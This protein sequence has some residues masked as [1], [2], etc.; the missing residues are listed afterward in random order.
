MFFKFYN[1]N[2]SSS[3]MS[4][5]YTHHQHNQCTR[6]DCNAS[7]H[8]AW[9]T[10]MPVLISAFLASKSD[11]DGMDVDGLDYHVFQ[12]DILGLR[13]NF[14]STFSHN[15]ITEYEYCKLIGQNTDE[16]ANVVLV[17]HGLLGASPTQP[18][19]AFTLEILKFYHQLHNCQ[20][21]LSIQAFIKVLCAI[22]NICYIL[23]SNTQAM[24]GLYTPPRIPC[25]VRGLSELSE[26]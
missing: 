9:T 20:R 1:T 10:Q 15:N 11:L 3:S 12:I 4:S 24:G 5:G 18:A 23:N 2:R 16:E 17:C 6:Q 21:S 26:D 13:G 22:H 14:I 8:A 25:G 19:F 7:S